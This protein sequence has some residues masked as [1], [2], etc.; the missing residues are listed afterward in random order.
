MRLVILISLLIAGF[1]LAALSGCEEPS[2][3]AP[4][5]VTDVRETSAEEK[6]IQFKDDVTSSVELPE[7][8]QE[9]TFIDTKGNTVAIADY[10]AANKNV[11]L[12]FTEGFNQMICPYCKTQTSRL[13]ANYEKFKKLDTEVLV[14]YPGATDHLDEFVESARTTDKEQLRSVPF[15]I[16]LDEDF[17]AVDFFGIRSKLAHPSTYIIDKSGNVVLA[18]VGADM[19]ADRPSV[20]AILEK[21][22]A[23]NTQTP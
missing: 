15:P 2:P 16:V 19:T 3:V 14:V 8:V 22:K 21:L 5:V 12:V 18:Y 13:V 17:K 1:L 9:L 11:V 23:S 4:D 6:P 10:K 7:S 20:K